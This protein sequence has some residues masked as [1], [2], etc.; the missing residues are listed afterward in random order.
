LDEPEE[1][2]DFMAKYKDWV[3]IKRI[4]IRPDTKPEAVVQ[5]LAGVRTTIDAKSFPM[6]QIKTSMLDEHAKGM[7]E[8][9][10][11]NYESLATAMGKMGS[12]ETKKVI[13]ESSTEELQPIA[14]IYLLGKVMS[15]IGYDTSINQVIMAKIYPDL[16]VKKPLGRANG[17]K[18]KGKESV[19]Y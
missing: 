11:K 16:K 7:C 4:G 3:S 1:Y 9:L 17:K 19:E 6:L 13:A 8:G 15:T 14:E 18:E 12:S 10:R 5:Y 2:I